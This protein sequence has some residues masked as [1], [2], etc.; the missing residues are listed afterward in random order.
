LGVEEAAEVA[1]ELETAG[2]EGGLGTD[3]QVGQLK[4]M[5]GCAT[6][7]LAQL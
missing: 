1:F 3:E 5:I 4:I 6:S 2:R 7:A